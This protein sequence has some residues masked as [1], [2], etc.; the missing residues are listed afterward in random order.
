MYH[1][2]QS[3]FEASIFLDE[4]IKALRWAESDSGRSRV[5]SDG[6]ETLCSMVP[7]AINHNRMAAIRVWKVLHA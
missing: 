2:I 5:S 7:V 4:V 6:W 3:W 1:S